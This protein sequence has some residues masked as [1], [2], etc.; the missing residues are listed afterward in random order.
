MLSPHRPSLIV[1]STI[2]QLYFAVIDS[3]T[4]IIRRTPCRK[5]CMDIVDAFEYFGN[6]EKE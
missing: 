4:I 2:F 6:G 1:Q 3:H 5:V